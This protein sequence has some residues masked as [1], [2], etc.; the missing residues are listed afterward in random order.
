MS[1]QTG[2]SSLLTPLIGLGFVEAAE[3]ESEPRFI[4]DNSVW[5]RLSTDE[6]VVAA[7]EALILAHRPSAIMICPPTVA[8]YGFSARNGRDHDALMK[9]LKAFTECSDAPN[10]EQTL[11]IQNRLWNAGLIRAAGAIDTII[12]A[13]AIVNDAT[14]I[15]YDRDFEIIASVVP[16]LK[17][18]WIAPRG[19]LT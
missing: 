19:S 3:P 2:S 14:V 6:A 11:S 13:Y 5:A 12:A 16:Q 10:S 17:H 9:Q 4:I 15:H 18:A 8:E 1:A 7:F